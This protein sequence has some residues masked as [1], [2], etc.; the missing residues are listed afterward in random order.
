MEN[1][2]RVCLAKKK[3]KI[4]DVH[5]GTG[6]AISTLTNLYYERVENPNLKTILKICDFL[7]ITVTEFLKEDVS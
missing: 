3:L 7:G 4:N 1:N 2:L 6:I 5:K